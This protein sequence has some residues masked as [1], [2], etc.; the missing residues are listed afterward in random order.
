MA[1]ALSEARA[2]TIDS[3]CHAWR[4]WPYPPL[5]PDENSRGTVE[6]LIYELDTNAV[7]AALV[8]C[9]AIENNPDN[10]D[11]V[12]FAQQRFP[13]RLHL[14]ADLDC[15]W[16]ETYHRPG[17]AERLRVLCD[18]YRLAGFTHYLA[19]AND[20]WLR[21]DEAEELFGLAAE[22]RLI[23]SLGA[24][25][26]WHDDLRLI[27]A[28][29]PSVPVLLHSLGGVQASEGVDADTLAR[30]LACV[31]VPSIYLKVA[32]LHYCSARGWD[33]PWH[34]VLVLLARIVE[35]FGA[36]RLC[37]GS[38]FPANTRFCT[39]RQ[40]LET[41]RTHCDFLGDDELRLVLGE[42]LQA[43]LAGR[44]ARG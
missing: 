26:P 18:R 2:P 7:D 3:H 44:Q 35:A 38:D 33:Y 15:S 5:V 34:D 6:Q 40:S 36:G 32:G 31:A 13:E 41:I 9:A 25:P 11:Y 1:D 39:Y 30:L 20:G 8:V 43:L 4:R 24:A 12:A 27:A 22:R 42:N 16:S 14:V 10:L 28:R 37:W 21:S 23:I 29:H 17:S 19:D